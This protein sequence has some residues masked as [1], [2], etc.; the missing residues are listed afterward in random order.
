MQE[1][2][3]DKSALIIGLWS[4]I[5]FFIAAIVFLYGKD[6]YGGV[7]L[8]GFQVLAR[9]WPSFWYWVVAGFVVGNIFAYLAWANYT[10]SGTIGRWFDG[11]MGYTIAF[12]IVALVCY[13]GPWGVACGYKANGGFTLPKIN[14]VY[15]D[16]QDSSKIVVWSSSKNIAVNNNEDPLIDSVVILPGGS[17]RRI[18]GIERAKEVKKLNRLRN[19]S[20]AHRGN[21]RYNGLGAYALYDDTVG[22]GNVVLGW[23]ERGPNALLP[24]TL[25][26]AGQV[27]SIQKDT[28][29]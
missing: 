10:G 11:S 19:G 22:H 28:L 20:A 2:K 14:G 12:A 9:V 17:V 6:G 3:K 1:K 25:K 7:E 18:N 26:I 24:D 8:T 13:A 5:A 29:K 15:I 21:I 23:Y 27:T 16:G 4:L